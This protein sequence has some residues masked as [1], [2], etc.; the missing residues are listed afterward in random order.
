MCDK[1]ILVVDDDKISRMLPGILLRPYGFTVIECDN[2]IEAL[3]LIKTH[4]IKAMLI[5]ISMSSFSGLELAKEV[6]A[7]SCSSEIKLIA[8]TADS[9]LM[10]SEK[11][12]NLGF[13]RVLIKPVH[14]KDL[15]ESLGLLSII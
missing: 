6:L 15:L 8:Y 9:S 12:S 2:G 7:N 14:A 13:D 4:H 1:L 10:D 5:D 11:F 3:E